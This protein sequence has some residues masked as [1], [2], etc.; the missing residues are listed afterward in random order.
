MTIAGFLC[1]AAYLAV[2]YVLVWFAPK[3]TEVSIELFPQKNDDKAFYL[4]KMRC[5]ASSG[6]WYVSQFVEEETE[7]SGEAFGRKCYYIQEGELVPKVHRRIAHDS[8]PIDSFTSAW[9]GPA[10]DG[11]VGF[12]YEVERVTKTSHGFDI[13]TVLVEP[14]EDLIIEGGPDNGK[15]RFLL[16]EGISFMNLVHT[17]GP[18]NQKEKSIKTW[19]NSVVTEVM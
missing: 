19:S 18:N 1:L 17:Q 7:I 5:L 2:Y 12:S 13:G 8:D 6:C 3:A 11:K 10:R 4:P 14:V 9:I 15:P 16:F